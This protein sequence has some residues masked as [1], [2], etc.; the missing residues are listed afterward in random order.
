MSFFPDSV[1]PKL[2]PFGQHQSLDHVS[3]PSLLVMI[4]DR[5]LRTDC[6]GKE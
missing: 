6:N 3:L 4:G 5:L 1:F 2:F